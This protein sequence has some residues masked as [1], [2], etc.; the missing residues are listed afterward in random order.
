MRLYSSQQRPFTE[1]CHVAVAISA[2]QPGQRHIGILHKEEILDETRLAQLEQSGASA[3]HLAFV[4]NEIGAVRYRPEDVAD[5]AVADQLPC[6]FAI[7]EPL[8]QEVLR[9]LYSHGKPLS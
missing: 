1:I 7:A 6:S 4:K 3:E 8:G 5:C 9:R 2:V